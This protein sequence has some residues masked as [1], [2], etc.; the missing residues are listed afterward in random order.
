MQNIFKKSALKNKTTIKA[1]KTS[2]K[3]KHARY[4]KQC[5]NKSE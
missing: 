3:A 1:K 5:N 4:T 2:T